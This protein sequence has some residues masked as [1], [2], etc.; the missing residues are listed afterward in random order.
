[1]TTKANNSNA[2]SILV[3][4]VL[5]PGAACTRDEQIKEGMLVDVTCVAR[6]MG[7]PDPVA[8]TCQAEDRCFRIDSSD[9]DPLNPKRYVKLLGSLFVALVGWNGVGAIRFTAPVVGG[10]THSE[11]EE[12]ELTAVYG[13][14]DRGRPCFTVMLAEEFRTRGGNV[15]RPGP[16]DTVI[17]TY[18]RKQAIEDG[19]LTDVSELAREAGFKVPT[20]LTR[21]AWLRCVAVPEGVCGQDET[22]RLWDVLNILRYSAYANLDGSTLLFRVCVR[23]G[24]AESDCEVVDLKAVCGPD[25]DGRPC[26]TV[27]LPEED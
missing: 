25:D 19:N 21:G 20:A 16:D 15:R 9:P 22:G 4:V 5:E 17:A 23:Y 11:C 3:E 18:S 26:L 27:M 8:L 1:M 24:N 7:I 12:V 13:P 14:D 10:G 2:S 6:L